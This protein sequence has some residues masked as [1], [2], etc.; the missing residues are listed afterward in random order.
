MAFIYALIKDRSIEFKFFVNTGSFA[1]YFNG[2]GSGVHVTWS[3]SPKLSISGE[4]RE[5]TLKEF[6]EYAHALPTPNNPP[7]STVLTETPFKTE[8]AS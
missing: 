8:L 4:T 3:T 6:G 1:E 2:D 7:D 5:D